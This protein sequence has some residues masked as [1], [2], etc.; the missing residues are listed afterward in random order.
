MPY[1]ITHVKMKATKVY[2]VLLLALD[3]LRKR[4]ILFRRKMKN[5]LLTF[6]LLTFAMQKQG[7]YYCLGYVSQ[8]LQNPKIHCP[9]RYWMIRWLDDLVSKDGLKKWLLEKMYQFSKSFG[10]MN[11][12]WFYPRLT[13]I[14]NLVEVDMRKEDIYFWRTISIQKQ[15][16]C[17]FVAIIDWKLIQDC[18]Y[19]FW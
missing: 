12:E 8:M 14:V 6:A 2:I 13:F 15:V 10:R 5:L 11:L 16:A 18:F 3:K 19:G 7:Y 9:H 4:K 17:V 1:I